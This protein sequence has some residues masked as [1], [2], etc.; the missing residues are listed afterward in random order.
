MNVFLVGLFQWWILVK[1]KITKKLNNSR[2]HSTN[3][4]KRILDCK[5]L[6][7]LHGLCV[8]QGEVVN[9]I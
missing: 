2:L 5:I 6:L 7:H 8:P 3:V 9:K 1:R 4:K